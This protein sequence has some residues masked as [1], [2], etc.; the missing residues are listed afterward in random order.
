[1][2]NTTLVPTVCVGRVHAA[3]EHIRVVA[4]RSLEAQQQGKRALMDNILIENND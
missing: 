2:D 3:K 1:M 4:Q